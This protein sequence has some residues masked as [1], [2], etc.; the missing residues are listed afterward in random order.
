MKFSIRLRL[1]WVLLVSIVLLAVAAGIATYLQAKSD[2]NTLFDYEIRQMTLTLSAHVSAHP[3][4]ADEPLL[5]VEHDFVTQI[6]SRQGKL[7][8]SSRP[9]LGPDRVMPE[10]FGNFGERNN[11]W[12]T[13][14]ALAGDY[15]LQVA[16]PQSLRRK[17]TADIALKAMLPVLMIIPLGGLIVWL[18]VGYGLKPLRVIAGEVE[19]RDPASLQRI[20]VARMPSEV[21]PLVMSLND[22]LGRLE[23]ALK[24][25]RAFIADA[26]HEL[27]TPVA[28]LSLQLGLIETASTPQERE[29]SMQDLK[30][31]IERMQRLIEQILTLARLDP[32]CT[33]IISVVDIAALVRDIC[34]DYVPVA[35]AKSIEVKAFAEGQVVVRGD[36]ASLTA[37]IRNIIDNAI[38]YTPN[39]GRVTL[40][41]K[42]QNATPEVSISDSGPGIPLALRE[43]VFSRFYRGEHVSDDTGTG[44]GLAIAKR[45]AA[46]VG[47]SLQLLDN[48]DGK[49]L[50]VLIRFSANDVQ[51]INAETPNKNCHSR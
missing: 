17:I 18:V 37:L 46:R 1:L 15:T 41:V 38:R 42:I 51:G 14:T 45:A 6:W 50:T 31:G 30:R 9:G 25:E 35:M 48:T 49:G 24:S 11:G 29:E 40:R 22:L 26:S 5:R 4:L 28:A 13:F 43:K 10:G 12:R 34:A 21:A 33:E 27:R 36:V 47:A 19:S 8:L 20:E 44:L 23:R 7:Q 2:V 39:G 32:E 3:E 16:Q